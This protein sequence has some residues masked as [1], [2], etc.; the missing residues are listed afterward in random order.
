MLETI[1]ELIENQF[2]N[3]AEM[4]NINALTSFVS[5]Y[6]PQIQITLQSHHKPESK[7]NHPLSTPIRI[8]SNVA[9]T[10]LGTRLK[11]I[12]LYEGPKYKNT[13]LSHYQ[14]NRNRRRLECSMEIAGTYMKMIDQTDTLSYRTFHF[15]EDQIHNKLM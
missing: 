7:S 14:R 4:D 12:F 10:I 15:N 9:D 13:M 2:Q 3:H 6:I 1:G 11:P 8:S 5:K